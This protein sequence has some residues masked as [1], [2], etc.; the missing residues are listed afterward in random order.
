MLPLKEETKL[1]LGSNNGAAYWGKK[2][3]RALGFGKASIKTAINHLTEN[4]HFDIGNVTMKQAIG[5][6]MGLDLTQFWENLFLYS[7][8]EKY[9]LPLISSDKIKA[10]HSAKHSI[11]DLCTINDDGGLGR[12]VCKIYP[13]ELELNVEHQGDHAAFFNLDV[14]IKKRTFYR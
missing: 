12:S 4:C 1:L 2:I 6:P 10:T 13:K 14:T 3:K 5:I 7:Y 8:E 9:M 11:D